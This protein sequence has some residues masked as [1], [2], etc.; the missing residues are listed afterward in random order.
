M[1]IEIIPYDEKYEVG[2]SEM[3]SDIEQEFENPIRNLSKKNKRILPNEYWLAL[4]N[5]DVIGTVGLIFIEPKN[6]ILKSMMV[7]KDFRGKQEGLSSLLL[8]KA[9]A[10]CQENEIERIYLGTMLQFTAAQRFY[11]KNG[12]QEI[13]E[14]NLP[15]NFIGNPLDKIFFCK[16]IKEIDDSINR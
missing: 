16:K 7:R 10:C 2:V 15:E 6:A 14:E 3:L 9:I 12:F 8:N 5:K 13:A 11:Q 1:M 4:K